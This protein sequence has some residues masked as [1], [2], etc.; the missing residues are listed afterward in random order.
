[1][2]GKPDE[3][4][5]E[6]PVAFVRLRP[7]ATVDAAALRDFVIAR[8]ED[9]GVPEEIRFVESL[10][11]GRTGKVDRRKLREQFSSA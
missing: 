10:P 6:V 2:V 11:R 3:R 7:G 1:V 9:C 5:G 4:H 8:V